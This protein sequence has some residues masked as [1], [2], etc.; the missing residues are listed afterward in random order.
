LRWTAKPTAAEEV[1]ARRRAEAEAKRIAEGRR[2]SGKTPNA[3][4]GTRSDGVQDHRVDV[5]GAWAG[6]FDLPTGSATS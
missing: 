2:Q 3:E 6:V 4:R 1:E 5:S